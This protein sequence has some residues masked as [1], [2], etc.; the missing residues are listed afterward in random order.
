[1]AFTFSLAIMKFPPK[2]FSKWAELF[3]GGSFCGGGFAGLLNDLVQDDGEAGDGGQ[4]G[5]EDDGEERFL[6]RKAGQLS[7]SSAVS[8]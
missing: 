2:Y 4:H 6:G 1:M 5:A 8:T 3:G 7:I